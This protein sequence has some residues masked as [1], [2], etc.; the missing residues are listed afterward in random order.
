LDPLAKLRYR[1][2]TTPTVSLTNQDSTPAVQ[3]DNNKKRQTRYIKHP[4]PSTPQQL[5]SLPEKGGW[6]TNTTEEVKTYA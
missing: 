3:N 5:R 6:G 4:T 1:Y 2:T